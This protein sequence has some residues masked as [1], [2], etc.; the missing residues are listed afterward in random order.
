MFTSAPSSQIGEWEVPSV[1]FPTSD[2][3]TRK[4]LS[5]GSCRGA[6]SEIRTALESEW[7]ET[8][9][10]SVRSLRAGKF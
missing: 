7:I 10:E 2:G 5:N 4:D 8:L 1:T 3:G 9:D 6:L